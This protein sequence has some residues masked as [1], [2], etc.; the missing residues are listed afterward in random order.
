MVRTDLVTP[1][2]ETVAVPPARHDTGAPRPP[3]ALPRRR[4]TLHFGTVVV[5]LVGVLI[6]SSLAAG[7]R[8]LHSANEDRLLKQRVREV[9][10]VVAAAIPNVQTP[11]ASAAVLAEGTNA[12]E[13]S[14]QQ[15][16]API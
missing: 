14:F 7:A 11:L 10:A 4:W 2:A 9:S 12:D 15:L 5:L 16:M 1:E 8:S 3:A 13:A 6:T